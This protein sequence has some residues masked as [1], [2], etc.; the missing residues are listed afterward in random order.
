MSFRMLRNAFALS[1]S[2]SVSFPVLAQSEALSAQIQPRAISSLIVDIANAGDHLVAVGERGH[3]LLSQPVNTGEGQSSW[4]QV[5]TPVD[6]ELTKV[7]FL[8]ANLG[9]AVGH[10]ATIIHTQD[11]GQTWQVQ[12]QS[13]ALDKPFLDI[14]FVNATEGMA[15][16]AYGLF[17]RT[18]DGGKTWA[19]EFHQEL[20]FEEDVS[21]LED[22]K[23]SNPDAYASESASLLPHFNRLISLSDKRLLLVGELGLVAVSSDNG[24]H[25]SRTDFDYDGS[26]FNAIETSHGIYAIGLRGHVFKTD[27]TLSQWDELAMPV[28]ST[29]NGAL[30]IDE[31]VY[32]VGN[33]GVVI[34]LAADDAAQ[35]V[36]RR[37]GENLVTIAKDNL[38]IVW[39]G[40][41][42]GLSKLTKM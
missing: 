3:V 27:E 33:A 1:L 35:L 13:T 9:W 26:M 16:G 28:E 34:K 42:Q 21:Y 11:G 38:G 36:E 39:L 40:G 41:T 18:T 23:Q 20:L 14:L 22:L 5:Q 8:D 10:D 15:V 4:V 37:Q 31:S 32:L 25:F 6:I 7:F 17:Y 2:V 19:G 30:A 12:M 24:K 29:I